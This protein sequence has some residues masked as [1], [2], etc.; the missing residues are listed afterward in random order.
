MDQ[1][2]LFRPLSATVTV[3]ELTSYLRETLEGDSFLQDIWVQGEV[4]NVSRPRSGHVYFTLKDSGASLR[5]VIWRQIAQ[6]QA[7][8][9]QVG[10]AV[11]A[12]GYI[13]IYDA[14]G[15]YQLY[16]DQI[17]PLGE[18][19]LYQEFI[20]LKGRLEAEGLFDPEHKRPIPLWPRTIGVAT[21]P[22][23]AALQDIL[24]TLRRRYPLARV[25]LAPTPVQ[26]DEAPAGILAALQVLNSVLR[27]D[28]ILLARGGGSIEDL[29]AFNNERV[30][31]AIFESD[32]PVITGIG[33]ETDFTIADFT[34]DLRAPTPTAAAELATPDR[35]ELE[36]SLHES[37]LRLARSIQTLIKAEQS[38]LITLQDR[39]KRASPQARIRSH[40]QRTDELA[41][42]LE[43]RVVH[44]LRLVRS[45]L[46][47]IDQ[48]LNALNPHAVLGRG[49]SI[50]AL[51]DGEVVRRVDQVSRGDS[52]QVRVS[53]GTF[54]A[55]VTEAGR[56]GS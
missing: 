3:T 37:A 50:V 1:L 43:V 22:T 18:G 11:E 41:R 25:V 19:R 52:L 56:S 47:G 21:S 6:R 10:D 20:R 4:S 13:S 8:S 51:P 29:W 39:L 46:Q 44:R 7:A 48:R 40:R 45:A 36:I 24:N 5:C 9:L 53:D 35:T 31:R 17:R 33:H 23:G 26:G 55:E 28:V 30:A 12:H 38:D 42:Q 49:F 54:A 15:Q 2:P 34:A 14:G 32:V 27:P 16:A